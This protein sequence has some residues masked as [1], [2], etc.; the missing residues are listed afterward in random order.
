MIKLTDVIIRLE[1]ETKFTA[2]YASQNRGGKVS[3]FLVALV[4]EMTSDNGVS[5]TWVKFEQEF[6]S[7][8]G[9]ATFRPVYLTKTVTMADLPQLE[10]QIALP[11]ATIVALFDTYPKVEGFNTFLSEGSLFKDRY[12]FGNSTH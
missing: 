11:N 12:P 8:I 6:I 5:D 2:V 7:F 10:Y 1:P 4:P 3:L 9:D